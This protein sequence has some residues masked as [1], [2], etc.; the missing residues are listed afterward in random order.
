MYVVHFIVFARGQQGKTIKFMLFSYFRIVFTE[1]S[2]DRILC[3]FMLLCFMY[4][5]FEY[6]NMLNVQENMINALS[7]SH[8]IITFNTF[9]TLPLPD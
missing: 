4:E 7:C 1:I 2:L 3:F 5:C 8:T 9:H 6:E